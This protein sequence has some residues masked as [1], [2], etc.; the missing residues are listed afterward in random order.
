M[1]DDLKKELARAIKENSDKPKGE[2][3]VKQVAV[4]NGNV[5][6]SGDVS[7]SNNKKTIK[8]INRLPETDDITAPQKRFIQEKIRRLADRDVAKGADIGKSLASWWSRLRR[9][10]SVNSYVCL[11]QSQFDAVEK[12]LDQQVG[13]TRSKL[14]KT[15]KDTWRKEFYAA[16]NAKCRQLKHPKEWLYAQAYE[17]AGKKITSLKDLNDRDLKNLYQ[18]IFT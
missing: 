11:K 13:I 3:G 10:F 5:Q 18:T 12:W 16:L 8:R 14:R 15:D 2:S 6:I 17:I 1:S 4:G 7:I 9:K